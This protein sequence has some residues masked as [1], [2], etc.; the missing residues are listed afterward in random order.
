LVKFGLWVL[1]IRE[2]TNR[3]TDIPGVHTYTF[4]AILHI[5]TGGEIITGVW[6][7]MKTIIFTQNGVF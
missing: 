3:Q 6:N 5:P 1:E 7:L 2:Q 4:I